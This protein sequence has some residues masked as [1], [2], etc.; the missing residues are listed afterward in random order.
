MIDIRG[1]TLDDLTE[2]QRRALERMYIDSF[3]AR[4]NLTGEEIEAFAKKEID[5]CL[6]PDKP[7]GRRFL[8]AYNG[9]H[10][11]GFLG[12]QNLRNRLKFICEDVVK[13]MKLYV[14][15]DRDQ[16]GEV[17][18]PDEETEI[19]NEWNRMMTMIYGDMAL[20]GI[21]GDPMETATQKGGG[22][23]LHPDGI[24]PDLSDFPNPA[25]GG[26]MKVC[27]AVHPDYQGDGLAGRMN[28]VFE[29]RAAERG[30]LSSW[31]L[32]TE[33]PGI[34]RLNERAGYIPLIIVKPFYRDGSS[35]TIMAKDLQPLL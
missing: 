19:H 15:A 1:T 29:Q 5:Y 32:C 24:R 2:D 20:N 22:I 16:N 28:E 17:S 7:N 6:D 14:T 18:N 10:P 26:V 21:S 13:V 35:M 34:Q 23:Y 31:T 25:E 27:T 4:V 8:V 9:D 12:S 30:I 11:V 33:E 3:A